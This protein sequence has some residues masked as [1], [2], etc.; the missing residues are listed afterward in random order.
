MVVVEAMRVKLPEETVKRLRAD[1]RELRRDIQRLMVVDNYPLLQRLEKGPSPADWATFSAY[2][3]M[4]HLSNDVIPREVRERISRHRKRFLDEINKRLA[5]TGGGYWVTI[6]NGD[7]L[8]NYYDERGGLRKVKLG[9]VD[10]MN[11]LGARNVD[12]V[13]EIIIKRSRGIFGD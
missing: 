6:E 8:L 12:R 7:T 5:K 4:I 1:L 10:V 13:V 3:R 11:I 2:L 9:Y